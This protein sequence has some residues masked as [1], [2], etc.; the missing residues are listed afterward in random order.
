MH[1][2]YMVE[3]PELNREGQGII[4]GYVHRESSC[5]LV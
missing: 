5:I 1:V 4:R 2:T 3:V